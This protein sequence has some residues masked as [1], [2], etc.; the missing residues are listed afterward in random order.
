MDDA[1][2]VHDYLRP[3]VDNGHI[4][5]FTG[6]AYLQDF[7]SGD[8]WAGDGLV[9]RPRL[10]G[11]TRTDVVRLPGGGLDLW[12][13]NMVIPK[14]AA[15]KYTAELMID[16]GLRRGPRAPGSPT[17]C[18]TSRPVKGVAEEIM[19]RSTRSSRPT[20]SCS[21]RATSVE[22]HASSSERRAED[23]TDLERG[24]HRQADGPRAAMRRAL[25]RRGLAP[26]PAAA[27]GAAV[28]GCSSSSP[29]RPD[30]P[31]VAL[32][33]APSRPDYALRPGTW[34]TTPTVVG[35]YFPC[36]F[37]NSIVY[38]GLATILC[39]AD[40]LSAGLRDRVPRRPLQEPAAVPGH[41]AVLH[42][43]P[44]SARSRGG[45][46]SATT[47]PSCRSSADGSGHRP[48]ELQ[49][50]ATPLAVVVG[51]TYQFLPFMVAAAVRLARE[52]RQAADRGRRGPVRRAVAAAGHDR[53]RAHRR[54]LAAVIVVGAGIR[55][56]AGS[57]PGIVA[58]HRRRRVGAA[59]GTY[60][61]SESF[62][63]VTLP[64]SLRACSRARILTF[65]PAIGDY[66]N[67][68]LLGNPQTQ[69]IGNVI[70]GRYLSRT[71]TRPR[72]RCRSS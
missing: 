32:G 67:A 36:S 70:Q 69:M 31:H 53:R 7:G 54:R 28:A 20:R 25:Q 9:G 64:L 47:A 2:V 17:S 6:N 68:E 43:L 29:Q 22:Q 55:A 10:V 8:T 35:P 33:R 57:L 50:L 49:L 4:R 23:E 37:A 26:V 16:F 61:I 45:S 11:G 12:T 1:Q 30:V 60:L 21:R 34:T 42:E 63:R 24:G 58:A 44:A 38:G 15:N 46:S 48:D 40:R 41:R 59:V 3:F 14:G 56:R 52:D 65:I 27:P 5:A 72:R 51:L 62:I 19:R 18:T 39:F 13:D 66:V 71:T